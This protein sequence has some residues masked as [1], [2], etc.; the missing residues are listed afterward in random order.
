MTGDPLGIA[1]ADQQRAAE[2]HSARILS[3][4]RWALPGGGT[5]AYMPAGTEPTWLRA[6]LDRHAAALNGPNAKACD[7]VAD[8]QA[9]PRAIVAWLPGV[10]VCVHCLATGALLPDPASDD[11]YR[12]DGCGEVHRDG[13]RASVIQVLPDTTL[14]LAV[15]MGCRDG[16]SP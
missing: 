16:F 8:G 12:C 11:E 10:I 14:H 4:Y 9:V 15:C 1:R 2:A 13:L 3:R 6:M 5:P 7:H